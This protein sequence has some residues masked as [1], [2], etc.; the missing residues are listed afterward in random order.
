MLSPFLYGRRCLEQLFAFRLM[1]LVWESALRVPLLC[2]GVTSL[3]SACVASC[4][5]QRLSFDAVPLTQMLF[6]CA[7]VHPAL[8]PLLLL[9][10]ELHEPQHITQPFKN[11]PKTQIFQIAFGC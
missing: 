6:T 8:K 7:C 11:A 2:I 9:D 4:E 5:A 3:S 1:P 10:M